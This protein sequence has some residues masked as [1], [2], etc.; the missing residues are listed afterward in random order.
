M[1]L[2]PHRKVDTELNQIFLTF[3]D[4]PCPLVTP[5]LL[6]ALDEMDARATFFIIGER[7]IE[8]SAIVFDAIRRGHSVGD[9]SWDHSYAHFFRSEIHLKTWIGD[10]HDRI[11]QKFGV[12]PVGFRS[13]AGVVTPPLTQAIQ[14]LEIPW[15][16]WN[17][18]F[19]DTSFPLRW[20]ASW[21]TASRGDIVLLHDKQ[22]QVYRKKFL[23]SLRALLV[24]L[25]DKGFDFQALT[26]DKF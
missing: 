6:D 9:H 20:M 11:R 2:K 16:H 22:R 25:K 17:Q 15:I 10:S 1:S 26:K 7:A 14:D 5:A 24:P 23:T 19:F 13:P 18:R 21:Y 4:G 3:D 8:N 12:D